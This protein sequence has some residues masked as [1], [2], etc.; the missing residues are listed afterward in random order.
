MTPSGLWLDNACVTAE[1]ANR[2]INIPKVA[3][4]YPLKKPRLL[5]IF[6]KAKI[7]RIKLIGAR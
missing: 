6:I 2:D 3:K 1:K 5:L 7:L 4:T